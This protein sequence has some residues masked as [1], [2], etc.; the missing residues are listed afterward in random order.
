M[1]SAE[2]ECGLLFYFAKFHAVRLF[3]P[4]PIQFG[5]WDMVLFGVLGKRM[6][7]VGRCHCTEALKW[8][9][10]SS[11]PIRNGEDS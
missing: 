1:T 2:R 9:K 6:V 5:G 3:H 11:R 10:R 4:G 8:A 7:A